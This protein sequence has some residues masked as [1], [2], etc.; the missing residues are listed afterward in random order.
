M[1][2]SRGFVK[3]FVG[4]TSLER[5]QRMEIVGAF[6]V[7]LRHRRGVWILRECNG[8]RLQSV[9]RPQQRVSMVERC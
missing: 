6:G 9:Q 2:G 3:V 5:R 1:S 7:V 4:F 8:M